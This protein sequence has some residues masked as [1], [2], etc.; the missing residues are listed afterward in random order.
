VDE[1]GDEESGDEEEQLGGKRW[2]VGN[3]SRQ[4]AHLVVRVQKELQTSDHDY[5]RPDEDDNGEDEDDGPDGLV[6]KAGVSKEE[7]A[8]FPITVCGQ[9]GAAGWDGKVA[10]IFHQTVFNAFNTFH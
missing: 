3:V 10:G 8:R 7:V 5:E 6:S 2:N 1:D 9:D 4:P